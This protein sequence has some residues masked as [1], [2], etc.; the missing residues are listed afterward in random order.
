[1]TSAADSSREKI[2]M[3]KE[4]SNYP[5]LA[6]LWQT[7]LDYRKGLLIFSLYSTVA[8]ISSFVG[9]YIDWESPGDEASMPS[10][11]GIMALIVLGLA[12]I[13]IATIGKDIKNHFMERYESNLANIRE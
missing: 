6:A 3:T 11:F 2:T 1:M 8:A 7:I 13:L 10:V 4:K 9:W 12:H 5:R